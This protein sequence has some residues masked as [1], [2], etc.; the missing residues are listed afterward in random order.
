MPGGGGAGENA[1]LNDAQMRMWIAAAAHPGMLGWNQGPP[2]FERPPDGGSVTS[3]NPDRAVVGRGIRVRG[4]GGGGGGGTSAIHISGNASDYPVRYFDGS[5]VLASTDLAADGFGK[6]FTHTRSWSGYEGTTQ[7]FGWNLSELPRLEN[8]DGNTKVLVENGTN[9]K[10]FDQAS[11]GAPWVARDFAAE[12]LTFDTSASEYVVRDTA[13]NE[14]R[15]GGAFLRLTSIAHAG[16]DVMTTATFDTGSNVT[17]LTKTHRQT[18][19]GGAVQVSQQRFVYQYRSGTTL[20]AAS[21]CASAPTSTR[22]PTRSPTPRGRT[23]A[24][25]T[26]TTTRTPGRT[27]TIRSSRR[28]SSA[29]VA[30]CAPPASATATP[31]RTAP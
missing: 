15:F 10:F 3:G 9:V 2:Q 4:G 8:Y 1:G 24:T 5:P 23:C 21:R 13:G 16:T 12:S 26:T 11:G 17:S 27:A 22:R 19:S 31:P 18:L 7:G 30:T 28:G 6:P 29:A 25:P 20:S 14:L